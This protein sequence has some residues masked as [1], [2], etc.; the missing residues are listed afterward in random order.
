MTLRLR[1]PYQ[2]ALAL[3]AGLGVVAASAVVISTGAEHA[4]LPIAQVQSQ[5][6]TLHA[7]RTAESEQVAGSDLTRLS[8][9]PRTSDDGVV[10]LT[11]E[12]GLTVA[13][14]G[15]LATLSNAEAPLAQVTFEAIGREGALSVPKESGP[16]EVDGY[17]LWQNYSAGGV[18]VSEYWVVD[19]GI[20][21][22]YFVSQRPAGDGPLQVAL[23]F[24][25]VTAAGDS[26]S[27]QLTNE[28]GETVL[29]WGK[30]LAWDSEGQVLPA[31][32]SNAGN[33]VALVV[34]DSHASYPIVID[35][36]FTQVA[37]LVS[38]NPETSAFFSSVALDG[39]T[40]V[41]GAS[42]E[43]TSTGAAY[44]FVRS[45]SSWTQQAR[46]TASDGATLDF[47]GRA[48]AISGDTIL[49]GAYGDGT[50]EGGSAYVFV[51]SGGSWTQTK[52]LTASDNPGNDRFAQAVALSGDTAVIG[53]S[54]HNSSRGAAYV[55]VR[56]AG[57]WP[58]NETLKVTASDGVNGDSFGHAVSVDGDTI[59]VG[60][61]FHN[62]AR[63]A[64]Y[65]FERVGG[66]WQSSHSEKL[67]SSDGASNDQFGFSVAVSGETIIGGAWGDDDNGSSSGSAYLFT[68]AGG[69]WPGSE[70][71]KLSASDGAASDSFGQVVAISGGTAIVGAPD[72]DHAGGTN[73]GSTYL[74]VRSG[75]IWPTTETEKLIPSDATSNFVFGSEVS[76]NA[77][78]VGVGAT[79]A[80]VGG[81]SQAG[82][83]YVFESPEAEES[84]PI[85]RQPSGSPGIF[86]TITA[87]PGRA[88]SGS[89]T[90]F[91]AYAVKPNSPY[92]LTIQALPGGPK[93]ILT[94]GATN[95]SGHLEQTV[96]LPA[97]LSGSQLVTLVAMG[98]SGELLQLGNRLE[99]DSRGVLVSKTPE[100]AQPQTR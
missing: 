41:V 96:T 59:V 86:L 54:Y 5:L 14:E 1:S 64:A 76:I 91:G 83:V 47:F 99:I 46:L 26:D 8:A 80:S 75:G 79:L 32:F 53:S 11:D 27:Q 70:T 42:G 87:S 37:K 63:G 16:S 93:A 22:G 100:S 67:A 20:E 97:G 57:V 21:H 40:I 71:L 95:A 25:G 85:W 90:T 12:T 17:T 68:R 62:S 72:D 55:F 50:S 52:K 24:S 48:V 56:T 19:A 98:A 89:S 39:D 77:G 92:M 84:S 28:S 81:L 45:G 51:R 78:V 9:L 69:T 30:L 74:F 34:D 13:V 36:T 10:R 2:R 29:D 38:P 60:S 43:G 31:R 49:I 65:V 23:R 33:Q 6:T 44:V 3:F 73:S 15:N 18:D 7:A 88:L 35:P 82:A 4:Q 58:D 66:A 61:P 94:R